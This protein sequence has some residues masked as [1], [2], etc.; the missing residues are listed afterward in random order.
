VI[1]EIE[2]PE[3]PGD[4]PKRLSPLHGESD[5]RGLRPRADGTG[6]DHT[7]HD[8]G[9]GGGENDEDGGVYETGPAHSDLLR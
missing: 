1:D 8:P 2:F 4:R 7:K 3:P 5:R 9:T 6:V